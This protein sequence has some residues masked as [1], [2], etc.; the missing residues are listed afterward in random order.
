MN[1]KNDRIRFLTVSAKNFCNILAPPH[2][3][4]FPSYI[5][6]DVNIKM[7]KTEQQIYIFSVYKLP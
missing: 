6:T 7:V 3:V 2:C 1:E 5:A 4:S